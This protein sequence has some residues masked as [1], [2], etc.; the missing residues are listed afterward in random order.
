[1]ETPDLTSNPQEIRK[2]GSIG[3]GLFAA[4]LSLFFP[5]VGQA[6]N[7]EIRKAFACCGLWV[8][9]LVVVIFTP[10]LRTFP[11]MVIVVT[12]ELYFLIHV[13]SDAFLV[14]KRRWFE[15]VGRVSRSSRVSAIFI[16][17]AIY[18]LIIASH[19]TVV[20]KSPR[21]RALVVAS[22]SMEPTLMQG[23]RMVTD[24][25]YWWERGPER[26]ELATMVIPEWNPTNSDINFVWRVIAIGGDHI[27]IK[28]GQLWVNGERVSEEHLQKY[29]SDQQ[30]GTRE[31][32]G[33][34]QVPLD[35]IFVLG[36]NRENSFD[37][38]YRG[39]IKRENLRGKPLYLYWSKNWKRIGRELK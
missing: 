13:V 18:F 14:G 10:L 22:G 27:S 29:D 26:G 25:R 5:G 39:S 9:L 23:D 1:M 38:R 20:R 32:F 16:L 37:S 7:G 30:T 17:L 24:P 2:G 11:G 8:A 4:L 12:A 36:D 6:Y 35:E 33:P 34:I 19:E 3:R 31:S 21:L 15:S 28:D